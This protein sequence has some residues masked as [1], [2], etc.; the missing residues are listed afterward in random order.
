MNLRQIR[1]FH[2]TVISG[3]VSK[4]AESIGLTQPAVS[5]LI[6]NLESTVGYKLF[7]RIKGR[8]N[9]TPEARF[10]FHE[11]DNILSQMD[12]L[13]GL[14][15]SPRE[16]HHK[17]IQIG[18][19]SG[20]A[21]FLLPEILGKLSKKDINFNV[22][23]YTHNSNIICDWIS[24]QTLDIGLIDIQSTSPSYNST[25]IPLTFL[26]AIPS[27]D[28][29]IDKPFLTP[30]DLDGKPFI[31]LYKRHPSY[32]KIER[33]FKREKATY[34]VIHEVL[35]HMPAISMVR[36][37][38]GYAFIDTINAWS[39][40]K[41][42]GQTNVIFK[43][44]TPHIQEDMAIITPTLRP[45]SQPVLDLLEIIKSSIIEIEQQY[46]STELH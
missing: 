28:P 29:L 4:A 24:R 16:Y 14:F 13:D 2:A 37:G 3:S 6:Q 1:A 9:P 43:P 8:I 38:M 35:V 40:E 39:Y 45:L 22:N 17:K 34:N 30:K 12:R 42:L 7:K 25:P 18:A 19:L 44:F 10:L 41:Y 27:N 23:L 36:A 5:K 31:S 32:G 20:P 21:N 15:N 46:Y 26:C 33:I 11:V